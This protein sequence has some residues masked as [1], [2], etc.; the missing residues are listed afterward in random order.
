MRVYKT[1]FPILI[2]LFLL[3]LS[4]TSSAVS[5]KDSE[6]EQQPRQYLTGDW[7]GAR[8]TLED[9]GIKPIITYASDS[10]GNP[11]GGES[12]GFTYW[13]NIGAEVGVDFEK[14]AGLT[15]ST[16]MVSASW[17]YGKSLTRDYIKNTFNVQQLCC[18]DT[19]KLVSLYWDQSFCDDIFDVRLGRLALGD[20]FLHSPI[21]WNFVNNG[22][23]GNPVGIFLNIPGVTA[24]PNATWGVRLRGRPR[25][26]LYVMAGVYNNDP[27][28]SNND[29]HGTD[30]TFRGPP[31]VIGELGFLNNVGE[32]DDGLP[33]HYKFGGYYQN[34]DYDDLLRDSNGNPYVVSG[35]APRQD[36]GNWGIYFLIDQ[37]IYS[38]AG[39]D[40]EQGLTPFFSFL[41]NPETNKSQMPIFMNGGFIYRGAIPG[42][43]DDVAGFAF[44]YG[45]YSD[46]LQM[47]QGLDPAA[48]GVQSYELVLEWN[49]NVMI[50]KW[51][52][53][54]PDIQYIFNPGG[55]D[56]YPNALVMGLQ[57]ALD[58]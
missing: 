32:D 1:I 6:D 52:H 20:E 38:E 58:I 40:S 50:T 9:I 8:T 36:R 29:N 41:I 15:G 48:P 7:F 54:Q 26:D 44:I 13:Q 31:F 24:Y 5:K 30:F 51:L 57:L 34:G 4:S 23:D 18:G 10:L 33:G 11:V 22:V 55:A 19:Y 17:R 27:T 35:L 16:F 2:A 56:E 45:G 39:S 3:S 46:D 37:M 21:Y 25:E 53:V 28:L 43:D 12:Q 14:L 42:R 47:S 49:Y